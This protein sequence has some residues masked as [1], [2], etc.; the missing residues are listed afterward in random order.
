MVDDNM[1]DVLNAT[2]AV[3]ARQLQRERH[4]PVG[5]PMTAAEARTLTDRIRGDA[6]SLWEKIAD[7]YLGRADVALGYESWD[8]YCIT[9]FGSTRL[10][11][12]REERAEMVCSLRQS[13]LSIRAIASAAGIDK[14]T[15]QSDLVSEIHTPEAEEPVRLTLITGLD[16][17]RY[18]PKPKPQPGPAERLA[19]PP[20]PSDAE[21]FDGELDELD[22]MVDVM[23]W[24]INRGQLDE[25]ERTILAG[26]VAD[27]SGRLQVIAHKLRGE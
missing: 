21:T 8:T 4:R 14:N 20:P 9:E 6:E 23:T 11:L 15:V 22:R 10:R 17:K 5:E 25:D 13:G 16:R 1:R 26:R 12:P 3:V 24:L 19:E 18:P 7:A 2:R 27:Y